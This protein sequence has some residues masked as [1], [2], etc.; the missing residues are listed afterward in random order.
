[1]EEEFEQHNVNIKEDTQRGEVYIKLPLPDDVW[2]EVRDHIKLNPTKY[3]QYFNKTRSGL[4]FKL[5]VIS[6][7]LFGET[8][9][10]I[11]KHLH[12]I[13]CET[14]MQN[15][16]LVLV[17]GLSEA[18]EKITEALPGFYIFIPT[19]LFYAVLK[20]AVHYDHNPN[21]LKSRISSFT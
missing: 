8:L 13:C 16:K 6:K 1:M 5:D 9:D 12:S 14:S 3:A 2:D 20:G 17:G 10:L 18:R 19:N 21:V 4:E 15:R 11:L 7:E